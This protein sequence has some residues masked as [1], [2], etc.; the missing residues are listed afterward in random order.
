MEITDDEEAVTEIEPDVEPSS[1]EENSFNEQFDDANATQNAETSV[2]QY[3]DDSEYTPDETIQPIAGQRMERSQ[4]E[5]NV[6]P[7]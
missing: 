2:D 7:F 5:H 4:T 6:R 3:N 1:E